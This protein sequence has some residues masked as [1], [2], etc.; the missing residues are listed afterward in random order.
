MDRRTLLTG[1]AFGML[2][3]ALRPGKA[4]AQADSRSW[5]GSSMTLVQGSYRTAAQYYDGSYIGVEMTCS[6]TRDGSFDVT[7]CKSG[8]SCLE[9]KTMSYRGFTKRT[10]RSFGPGTYYFVFTKRVDDRVVV[11]STD[12]KT[13][14]W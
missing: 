7:C 6:A 11:K 4:F 2:G 13:Y 5:Y 3:S 14:S 10:W 12:V 1:F 8:G 9:T